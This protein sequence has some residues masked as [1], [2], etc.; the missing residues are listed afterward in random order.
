VIGVGLVS[1][2]DSG[3]ARRVAAPA[4]SRARTNS[5]CSSDLL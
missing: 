4:E 1:R 5:S 3:R 2:S